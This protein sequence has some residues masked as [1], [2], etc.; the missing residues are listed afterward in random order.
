MHTERSGSVGAASQSA[1]AIPLLLGHRGARLYAPE[2]TFEA[3]DRALA[4]GCN[5]I[6]FDVR[7]T[8]DSHAIICH[9]PFYA[10]HEVTASTLESLVEL[11]PKL[12]QLSD[13]LRRYAQRCFLYIELKVPGAEKELAYLLQKYPPAHGYVVAS[14]FPEILTRVHQE[15]PTI[16]LGLVCGTKRNLHQWPNL[17]VNYV[18]L[19]YSITTAGLVTRLHAAGKQV[20]AW[21]VNDEKHMHFLASLKID[22]ILSDDTALLARTF[23]P[24]PERSRS[25]SSQD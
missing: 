22:G 2:N 1:V 21:T 25:A 4:D 11:D 17:P 12:P 16:S 19:K 5:G 20:F 23:A 3:F 7:L 18:M 8:L 6:E 9:D 14:F 13:V 10:H 15:D 24:D